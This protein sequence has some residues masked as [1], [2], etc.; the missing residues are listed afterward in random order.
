MNT[1]SVSDVQ[2]RRPTLF[3]RD[4]RTSKNTISV[5]EVQVRT[6]T[7]FQRYKLEHQLC[8]RGISRIL[9]LFQKYK[10]E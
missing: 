4:N 5:S 8:F 1:V 7:L 10:Y 2:V 6:P 9:S 3:Q